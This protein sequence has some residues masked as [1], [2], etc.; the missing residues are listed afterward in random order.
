MGCPRESPI[1]VS[2][3]E[4]PRGKE[5]QIR[6][7]NV[8]YQ[9]DLHKVTDEFGVQKNASGGESL[10]GCLLACLFQGVQRAHG[11]SD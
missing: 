5:R 11:L 7:E 1:K 4:V 6:G 8:H 10:A 2:G 9:C 3:N